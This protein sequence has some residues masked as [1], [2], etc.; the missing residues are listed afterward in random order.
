MNNL[1]L[2]EVENRIKK[3]NK[4]IKF[5]IETDER[6]LQ[7]SSKPEVKTLDKIVAKT[8]N[9]Y[10]IQTEDNFI[11]IQLDSVLELPKIIKN[12]LG[13][14]HYTYGIKKHFGIIESILMVIDE[15]FKLESN[16][17]KEDKMSDI[18]NTILENV[19]TYFNNF[20]YSSYK[21]KKTNLVENIICR[22]LRETDIIRYVSD[23]LEV[24]T[25]VLD[26]K[27]MTYQTYGSSDTLVLILN[28]KDYL[29]PVINS[30]NKELPNNLLLELDKI[31]INESFNPIKSVQKHEI[32]EG[33]LDNIRKYKVTDL[34]EMAK[35]K[36]IDIYTSCE[37]KKKKKTKQILYDEIL[38][39]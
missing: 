33:Q 4:K 17:T 36:G 6:F 32:L 1:S 20:N 2:A 38:K 18:L 16:K 31:L 5:N 10:N 19:D 29:L 22:K 35:D 14:N 23:F 15:N 11:R 12:I 8:V 30:Y 28:Q 24:K 37:G 26:L 25:I 34:Q 27:K 9:K 3:N 13:E 39:S 7:G 21:I